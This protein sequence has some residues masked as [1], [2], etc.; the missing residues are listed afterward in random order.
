MNL[1]QWSP[2]VRINDLVE[3][4]ASSSRFDL[5][6]PILDLSGSTEDLVLDLHYSLLRPRRWDAETCSIVVKDL[7]DLLVSRPDFVA[8][9]VRD[10]VAAKFPEKVVQDWTEDLR[11]I[12]GVANS[13]ANLVFQR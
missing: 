13:A 12:L 8:A 6:A 10:R 4:S 9:G 3:L 2:P 1:D 5:L 7:L 11:L